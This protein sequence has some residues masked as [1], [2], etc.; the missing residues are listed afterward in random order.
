MTETEAPR[1]TGPL[2][3]LRIVE[4]G[5]FIAAPFATRVLGDL[6]AEIIKIEPPSGDPVR[7]WGEQLA[8]KSLWWS[9]HARNKKSV[10]LNLK[11]PG[12]RSIALQ[13]V[14]QSDAVIENFRPGLM[15]KLGL[16]PDDLAAVKPGCIFVRISGFG[17]TGPRAQDASFGMIGE[18]LGGIRHLTGYPPEVSELPPVRTGVSLGDTVSGLY[19]AIGLLAA[20]HEQ[21]ASAVPKGTAARIVDIALTESVLSLLEGILPEYGA[22]GKIR[23]PEGARLPAAAPSSAYPTADGTFVLIGA[24]SDPLFAQ[25]MR[26]INRHELI[27]DPRFIDNPSR[28]ANIDAIDAEIAEWTRARGPDAILGDLEAAGIPSSKIYTAADIV[29]DPQY[30]SRGAVRSVPDPAHG[31]DILQPAPVPRFVGD[32][33]ETI[34]WPGPEI[35]A[36]TEEVLK[37]LLGLTQDEY[38]SLKDAGTI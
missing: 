23:R 2:T 38:A 6:G 36:H 10:C 27:D 13:L 30:Q 22:L 29:A 19:G 34:A 3:G 31:L 26:L 37:G 33:P 32:N 16:G 1:Q 35:G 5:H 20:L 24:N 14:A 9:S 8:G 21:K 18:A 15:E 28:V 11:A 17:Q 7:G 4:F 12:A 25:L